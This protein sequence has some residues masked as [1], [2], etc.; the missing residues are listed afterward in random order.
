MAKGS[1]AAPVVTDRRHTH[2]LP[3][4]AGI[5][6]KAQGTVGHFGGHWKGRAIA[7]GTG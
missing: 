2:R 5:V 6:Q 4:A 3:E 7:G 1:V